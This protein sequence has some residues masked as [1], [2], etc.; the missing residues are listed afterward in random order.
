V[1]GVTSA[2]QDNYLASEAAMERLCAVTGITS[3][4]E[5]GRLTIPK[6][7]ARDGE[8]V[9]HFPN[10][11]PVFK[12]LDVIGD[13]LMR[14]IEPPAQDVNSPMPGVDSHAT[15]DEDGAASSDGRKSP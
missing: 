5:N 3:T 1:G 4:R 2:Q 13:R 6:R 9:R 15:V 14:A 7:A 10:C 11:A 8:F 12:T